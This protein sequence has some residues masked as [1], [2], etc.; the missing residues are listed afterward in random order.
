VLIFE[1]V[2]WRDFRKGFAC[3]SSMVLFFLTRFAIGVY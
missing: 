1:E 2:N 3:K